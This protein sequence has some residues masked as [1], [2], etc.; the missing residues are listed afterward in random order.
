MENL[1]RCRKC[2][3]LFK[4]FV[5]VGYTPVKEAE[6]VPVIEMGSVIGGVHVVKTKEFVLRLL[7]CIRNYVFGYQDE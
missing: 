4:N 1:Y 7:I 3:E 6:V 2:L 5:Q